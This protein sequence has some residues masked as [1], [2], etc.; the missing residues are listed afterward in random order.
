MIFTDFFTVI[1]S[2][3][4]FLTIGIISGL[5]KNLLLRIIRLVLHLA[6]SLPTSLYKRYEI[7][8]KL[9]NMYK[10]KSRVY[11]FFYIIFCGII[12]IL[13]NYVMLSGIFR[14]YILASC[15]I[16]YLLGGLLGRQIIKIE[17]FIEKPIILL[18]SLCYWILTPI[19]FSVIKIKGAAT[20][21]LRKIQKSNQY[22]VF[23]K[24]KQHKISTIEKYFKNMA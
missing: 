15:A 17:H 18:S 14:V 3:I 8:E 6:I 1:K 10:K 12:L 20:L 21:I 22:Y 16:G 23:R 19:R 5:L 4:L 7:K 9:K 11:E 2:V 13:T 24:L